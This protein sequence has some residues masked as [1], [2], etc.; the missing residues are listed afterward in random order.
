MTSPGSGAGSDASD[1]DQGQ[2]F[3]PDRDHH[4]AG[5]EPGA[6]GRPGEPRRRGPAGDYR[7]PGSTSGGPDDQRT[8]RGNYRS[9]PGDGRPGGNGHSQASNG[10]GLPGGPRYLPDVTGYRPAGD[11]LR[12]DGNGYRP[13]GS[14]YRGDGGNRPPGGHERAA[15][16]EAGWGED[17]RRAGASYPPAPGDYGHGGDQRPAAGNR[18]S[19]EYRPAGF[20]DR[21]TTQHRSPG[22][23]RAAG[24]GRH[25][26]NDVGAAGAGSRPAGD[27]PRPVGRGHGPWGSVGDDQRRPGNDYRPTAEY[28]ATDDRRP[29]GDTGGGS[30]RGS[31]SG[32]GAGGS[33]AGGSDSG[34]T[35]RRRAGGRAPG[36]H[37]ATKADGLIPGFGRA[38]AKPERG[39]R[40][41]RGGHPRDGGSLPV[42]PGTEGPEA[43]GRPEGPWPADVPS[44]GEAGLAAGGYGVSPEG[45][46]T[47]AEFERSWFRQPSG[48]QADVPTRPRPV[49]EPEASSRPEGPEASSRPEGPALQDP[50][51]SAAPGDTAAPSLVRSSSV[52]ALGTLASRVTGLVRSVVLVYALGLTA[53]AN[54]YNYANTLPNTVY[55]LAIG[56]ILTSVIVPLLVS[57]ARRHM[58][59][60]EQYDQRMFTLVTIALAGI[61]LVA[62]L[63]AAPIASLYDPK[64]TGAEHHLL[65]IFAYFFIPQ[66]FFYGVSSLAGAILNARNHF[67]APMWTPVVNNIVVTVI[68]VAFMVVA[69][70]QN[71]NK[72]A[73]V[74]NGEIL[75]L[76]IGTTLGIIAQTAALVPALRRVGFRWHP[77][78]DFR[79]TEIG[80]IGRMAGWMFG[81]VLTT[82]VAFLVT[83]I[84]ASTAGNAKQT[85]GVGAGFSAY[86]N[87]WLLFQLP[88]AIVAISVI[89]ALLP[90]MSG[91][92]A[93]RRFDLVQ[94]DFSTG[95]RLGSVV[96]AP[97]ALV[98][99]ALGPPLAEILL[100]WGNT[101]DASARYLGVV[102]SIFSLGLVPYMLFQLLLRVFY[103]LHDSKT[104]ALIGVATMA[105][106]AGANLIALAAFPKSEVVAALGAGFGLAN[107]V[108]SVLAW[109][110]LSRRLGGLAGRQIGRSLLRMHAAAAPA[111]IFALAVA[112]LLG[113]VFSTSKIYSALVVLIGGAGA[114]L[115]YVVAAKMLQVTEVTDLM[116][117]VRSRLRR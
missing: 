20:D 107:V 32:D 93:D 3:P 62:T 72:P 59:K 55:N 87:A 71:V 33:D 75:L 61:T 8:T 110:V 97:A 4:S 2:G 109:R 11:G 15:G 95:V 90:R 42:G 114:V 92:A 25:A 30:S 39:A 113:T 73:T 36:A 105:T 112:I 45:D 52:M 53:L 17:W 24:Q 58:D 101:S 44:P 80:E 85:G 40:G 10:G 12:Q 5:D 47:E 46:L 13:A 28:P 67:A 117:M 69:A 81:Y 91:H 41:G 6:S 68:A 51:A 49:R 57:A 77:R 23:D 106:N 34:A 83:S 16:N 99:A 63:A 76:G 103:A 86:S 94:A 78:F 37:R 21:S 64:A 29:A 14:G 100:G 60:G 26:G 66:I 35:Q 74:T 54:A 79:R 48:S 65:V 102:F 9:A 31:G 104:P 111:A 7:P 18:V 38:R 89:T 70:G 27:Q 84:V 88:Y 108:G 1:A 98:L 22:A 116:G 115:L 96:V 82:Q 19:G 56:G 43:S 50:A